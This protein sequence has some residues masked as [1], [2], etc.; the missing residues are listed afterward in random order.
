MDF[1]TGR[2]VY[3]SMT[4]V[5]STVALTAIVTSFDDNVSDE[6]QQQKWAVSAISIVM[7]VSW[8]SV[9]ANILMK[10]KFDNTMVE[11]LMVS[12]TKTKMR[13]RPIVSLGV[14]GVQ[15]CSHRIPEGNH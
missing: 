6:G 11:G 15:N 7:G 4:A 10:S 3:W 8:I 9:F 1:S 12:H 5:C 2:H 13:V 14:V